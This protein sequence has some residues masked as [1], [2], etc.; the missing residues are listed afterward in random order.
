M[1][2]SYSSKERQK[3]RKRKWL[4]RR[5]Y[6]SKV[7]CGD[8]ILVRRYEDK[9]YGLTHPGISRGMV[10]HIKGHFDTEL[11]VH[12]DPWT[13]VGIV[14]R[15]RSDRDLRRTQGIHR[16][17]KRRHKVGVNKNI[18][19]NDEA[20]Y[21]TVRHQPNI[22]IVD[23]LGVQLWTYAAFLRNAKE[24]H[25]IVACRC[26]ETTE[27]NKLDFTEL[28]ELYG[29]L[30]PVGTSWLSMRG[31]T[32]PHESVKVAVRNASLQ[33]KR[34]PMSMQQE[35]KRY[36][37]SLDSDNNGY[38]DRHEVKK[39]LERL[40]GGDNISE[41][42]VK[43]LMNAIDVNHDGVITFDEF[44][45]G[46][47]MKPFQSIDSEHDFCGTTSAELIADVYERMGLLT[48]RLL[49]EKEYKPVSFSSSAA[50]PLSSGST[51]SKEFYIEYR[52][53]NRFKREES[54]LDF[55]T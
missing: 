26:L 43:L 39:L 50:L 48:K 41:N 12:L 40:H 14:Y 54:T 3:I 38:I 49:I 7:E 20:P 31:M 8:L 45:I 13:S 46:F 51:L 35:L 11:S 5:D 17:S 25:Y 9:P 1:G 27:E 55:L 24:K 52:D 23:N 33:A 34:M 19:D 16:G 6:E 32:Y 30:L 15:T 36:F 4:T 28:D 53:E 18:N 2:S 29:K 22:I 21:D 37:L 47:S 44:L 10:S 42:K